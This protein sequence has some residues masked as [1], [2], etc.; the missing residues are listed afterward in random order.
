MANGIEEQVEKV[1]ATEGRDG[2]ET[3]WGSEAKGKR[4]VC[5]WLNQETVSGPPGKAGDATRLA[6]SVWGKQELE[7]PGA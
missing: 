3:R 2:K 7:Y 4:K 6:R 1:E 5:F